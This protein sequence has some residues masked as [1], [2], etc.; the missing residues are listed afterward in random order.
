MT[1]KLR[2]K[3]NRSRKG[4]RKGG[5]KY[6]GMDDPIELELSKDDPIVI[7]SEGIKQ[8]LIEKMK[9]K[10]DKL[11]WFRKEVVPKS[12]GWFASTSRYMVNPELTNLLPLISQ[13]L[14]EHGLHVKKNLRSSDFLVEIDYANAGKK[15]V[16]ADFGIH[17]DNNG[18][19]TGNVHTLM[20]CLEMECEGGDI[21][22]YT[23]EEEYIESFGGKSKG[24]VKVFLYDGGLHKQIQ[25]ITNG[26][27]VAVTYQIRTFSDHSRPSLS[28]A[29]K[30][31]HS[32]FLVNPL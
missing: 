9:T 23:P 2:R 19:I 27:R 25:P 22:F 12:L 29:T 11:G 5:S 30:R 18:G 31:L 26:K 32:S 3:H 7:F 15:P 24:G 14:N 8:Q 16:E 10:Y 13:K 1:R 20:V 28:E 4:T 6:E 17:Q 21:A